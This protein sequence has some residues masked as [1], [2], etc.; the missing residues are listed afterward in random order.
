VSSTFLE[1][2][3]VRDYEIWVCSACGGLEFDLENDENVTVVYRG[4]RSAVVLFEGRAH[5]LVCTTIEKAKRRR[6][7]EHK[8]LTPGPRNMYEKQDSVEE[9]LG[10]LGSGEA[11][12]C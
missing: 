4:H 12:D 9:M 11:N 5:S 8:A 7:I 6:D 3:M 2:I 1:K 10:D